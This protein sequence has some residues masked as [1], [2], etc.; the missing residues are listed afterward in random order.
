MSDTDNKPAARPGRMMRTVLVASLGLN[1]LVAGVVVGRYVAG[2][3][4]RDRGDAR[5][6]EISR[7]LRDIGNLPFVMALS[8]EDRAALDQ[9]LGGRRDALRENR[10]RLRDRFEAVLTLLRADPFQPDALRTLL[11]EQRATL[12]E[13][14]QL[15]EDLLIARLTQMTPAERADYAERLDKSL[16][17][18]PRD[19]PRP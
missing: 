3:R 15:G 16:R 2:D 1:L 9:A 19:A 7:E 4:D 18:G 10:Q 17:R 13:R 5:R 12:F 6:G 8:R 14:Q 11:A